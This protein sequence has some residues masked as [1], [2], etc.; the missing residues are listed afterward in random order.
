MCPYSLRASEV[1]ERYTY[2]L[3]HK[4]VVCVLKDQISVGTL[5]VCVCI[6]RIKSICRNYVCVF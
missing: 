5:C 6:L 4:C 3:G 2:A 1:L